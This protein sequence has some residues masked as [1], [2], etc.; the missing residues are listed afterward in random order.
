MQAGG[1]IRSARLRS[2]RR[3]GP[4]YFPAR[5]CNVVSAVGTSPVNSKSLSRLVTRNAPQ[6]WSVVPQS[7]SRDSAAFICRRILISLARLV[8][9]TIRTPLKSTTASTR[10]WWINW[11]SAS[12]SSP[13]WGFS[14]RRTTTTLSDH[15]SSGIPRLRE[16]GGKLA[17]GARSD[18]SGGCSEP[19]RCSPRPDQQLVGD[20]QF[21]PLLRDVVQE[22]HAVAVISGRRLNAWQQ[23]FPVRVETPHQRLAEVLAEHRRQRHRH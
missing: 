21:A 17:A 20:A 7:S 13:M 11:S 6:T 4:A 14:A 12:R 10:R 23:F 9:L 18:N 1:P 22:P 3:I 2:R 5:I 19:R 16:G 8:E 15:S